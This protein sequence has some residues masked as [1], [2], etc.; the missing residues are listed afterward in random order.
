MKNNKG[1]SLIEIIVVM[2]IL[3]IMAGVIIPNFT[4][5]SQL[6]LTA[7]AKSVDN[8]L[9]KIKVTTLSDA[10][11]VMQHLSLEWLTMCSLLM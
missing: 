5:I 3:V 2:S 8:N 4:N 9:N 10:K 6:N 1:F 11:T 7:C